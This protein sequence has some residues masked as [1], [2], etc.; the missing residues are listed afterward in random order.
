MLQCI[1]GENA[2]LQSDK[3]YKIYCYNPLLD[4]LA[5]VKIG[6]TLICISTYATGQIHQTSLLRH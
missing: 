2:K 3:I 6:F 1:D 5:S 4:D